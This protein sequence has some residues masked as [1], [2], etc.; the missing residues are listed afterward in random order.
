[1][2]NT[3]T[4]KWKRPLKA[5]NNRLPCRRNHISFVIGNEFVAYGGQDEN[6]I[7]HDTAIVLS[8][9]DFDWKGKLKTVTHR[10]KLPVIFQR[11]KKIK[12]NK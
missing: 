5:N 11:R 2:Y 7:I 9:E 3:I 6:G 12:E 4:G 1:M 8:L 10:V